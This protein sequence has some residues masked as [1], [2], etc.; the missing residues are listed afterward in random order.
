MWRAEVEARITSEGSAFRLRAIGTLLLGTFVAVMEGTVVNVALPSI[1]HDF[2]IGYGGAQVLAT[3]FLAATTVSMLL[4]PWAIRRFGL[5]RA[6]SA[7]NACLL[8]SSLLAVL[9]GHLDFAVLVACR[10]LQGV[11][12]GLIQPVAMVGLLPLFPS[13]AHGR[14]MATYGLGIVLAPAIGPVAGG[15][16]V[17]TL[18]WSGVFLVAVPL[19]GA[20]WFGSRRY[21]FEGR[22]EGRGVALPDLPSLA[23][24]AVAL[25]AL[26]ASV[27][28]M[29][30]D[31]MQPLLPV[32]LA[33]GALFIW[34]QRRLITPLLDPALFSA[35]GVGAGLAV[36]FVYGA[37]L[38]GS[39]YL[40]PMFAQHELHASAFMAGLLLLPGG[41][42]LAATLPLGGML[43]DRVPVRK[44][45]V[46]G[47][48]FFAGGSAALALCGPS[49]SLAW[50][51]MWV[52]LGRIGLGLLIPSLNGG[53][54]RLAKP[55]E[56]SAATAAMNFARQLGGALGIVVLA[57]WL[58]L[59]THRFE[60]ARGFN[61]GFAM[62]AGLFVLGAIPAWRMHR[63][64]ATN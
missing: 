60:A 2:G 43:A 51:A 57:A 50:V 32:G 56:L 47:L 4:A 1:Q 37:G 34:R 14:A 61:L 9:I 33:A 25:A 28:V 49:V 54:M 63:P 3:G 17:D 23:L 58:E 18:G 44:V 38:Y 41:V 8:L 19:S 46:S 30:R 10:I 26:L 53:V 45:V 5:R 55:S 42:A 64:A 13:N 11:A 15:L 59:A 12:A 20:A 22:G 24:V 16:L 27:P 52:V 35:P 62:V 48:L 36:A 21:L 7:A 39:T 31:P 40:I 29:G 6:F